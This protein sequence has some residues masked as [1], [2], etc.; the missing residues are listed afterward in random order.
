MLSSFPLKFSSHFPLKMSLHSLYSIAM[1]ERKKKLLNF[2]QKEKGIKCQK[3]YNPKKEEEKITSFQSHFEKDEVR[4]QASST[5]LPRK[6]NRRRFL[7]FFFSCSSLSCQ[8]VCTSIFLK[9]CMCVS[10]LYFLSVRLT[11]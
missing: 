2:L 10:S 7:Y 6:K 4:S 5:R 8:Y 3:I 1:R 9:M 11:Q